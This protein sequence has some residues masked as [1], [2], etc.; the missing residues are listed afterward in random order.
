MDSG[1][2]SLVINWYWAVRV[3]SL[4][5]S[6]SASDSVASS[7]SEM[8][9]GRVSILDASGRA[10]LGALQAQLVGDELRALGAKV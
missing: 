3:G 9:S 1:C 6:F 2:R 4:T 8:I 10:D 7:G 5:A